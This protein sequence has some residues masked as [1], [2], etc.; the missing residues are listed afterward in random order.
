ML[1]YSALIYPEKPDPNTGYERKRIHFSELD[2]SQIAFV[3]NHDSKEKMVDWALRVNID[4]LIYD[5]QN[6]SLGIVGEKIPT[7]D[8]IVDLDWSCKLKI[9]VSNHMVK[10]YPNNE[11]F[12]GIVEHLKPYLGD[13]YDIQDLFSS[14]SVRKKASNYELGQLLLIASQLDMPIQIEDMKLK[15]W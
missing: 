7:S 9:L 3:V 8:V 1:K 5:R 15:T 13:Q 10:L 12:L 14:L 11:S 2:C 6:V 4:Y